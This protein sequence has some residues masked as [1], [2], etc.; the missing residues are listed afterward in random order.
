MKITLLIGFADEKNRTNPVIVAGPEISPNSQH[1]IFAAAKT[2]Q[3]FPA[4]LRH[5]EFCALET[6]DTAISVQPA[7]KTIV[8][9]VNV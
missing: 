3:K 4:G 7:R 9:R 5:L 2:Q 1:V 6:L 8:T